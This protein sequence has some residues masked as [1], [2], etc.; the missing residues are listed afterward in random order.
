[1][2]LVG[3][4]A[5]AKHVT[6]ADARRVAE[7]FLKGVGCSQY[8]CLV[9]R[10]AELAFHQMYLF[11]GEEGGFVL[12]SADDCAMPI[13]GYSATGHFE[14]K[15]MPVHVA[16]WLA[17]YEEE[18]AHLA[19]CVD[20]PVA[21]W[22]ELL[23]GV[24]PKE[25]LDSAVE[26]LLTT[27]WNQSPF[28]NAQCPADGANES[29]HALAGCTAVATAQVMKYWN[30]PERGYGSHSYEHSTY[31]TLS[32]DFGSTTYPWGLMSNSLTYSSP[33]MNINAVA[34]LI[35]HV[36]VAV[37]ME[38]GPDR[39]GGALDN[40]GNFTTASAENALREFFKYKSSLNSIFQ[41]DCNP[42]EYL[43]ILYNELDNGRPVLYAGDEE[44]G[45]GHAFV[46]DGYDSTGAFHINWGWGGFEDGFYAIGALN[47]Y[48]YALNKRGRAIIGI[49]PSYDFDTA[50]VTVVTAVSFDTN[51]GLITGAGTYNFGDTV[52]LKAIAHEG[53][54]FVKWSD[55]NRCDPRT[56]MATGGSYD[57]TA[58]IEP[59]SGDTL[60]YCAT[61]RKLSTLGYSTPKDV[62]W[63]IRLP[64]STLTAGH[65]LR[66]V[67]LYIN[68]VGNYSTL[69]YVGN[70]SN[71]V[72]TQDF[73]ATD[74][75]KNTWKTIELDAPVPI[76][77]THDL[78]IYFHTTDLKYP[79]TYTFY[80][81]NPDGKLWG[82][83]FAPLSSRDRSFMIRGIFGADTTSITAVAE[84]DMLL[85]PNP[86]TGKVYLEG[87]VVERVRVYDLQG[88]EVA[89][90]GCCR[91]VDLRHLGSGIYTLHIVTPSSVAVK[92][93][94]V[95]K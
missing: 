73:V 7:T 28:Y 39:S 23:K 2:L 69:I 42:D 14:T 47:P 57:F 82:T 71:A 55:G 34:T 81:G 20:E 1:M 80:S 51:Y 77:G 21:Q 10:T 4:G 16:S 5:S 26:P 40:K 58:L 65:P 35:Y 50:S 18:I 72:H 68:S 49:E 44:T 9:D 88:R 84:E 29:G 79:A 25:A 59:L 75:D 45:G 60:S 93:V 94:V 38:Y 32:A 62:Y 30:F 67:Q 78:W 13:L 46:L 70:T 91:E 27:Q 66:K 85:Y 95:K 37:E 8:D 33:Q 41:S 43:Q 24:M 15:D 61:N 64:A 3:E 90:F 19:Q 54:R 6:P 11:T 17:G 89:T 83:S 74:S 36:G 76:D 53:C 87:A 12:V 31:G 63:G 56:F 48:N 52:D 22:R 86:T 92:R